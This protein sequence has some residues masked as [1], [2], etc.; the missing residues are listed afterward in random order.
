MPGLE[1]IGAD[2]EVDELGATVVEVVGAV[3]VV[4]VVVVV[5]AMIDPGESIGTMNL[6][7]GI[8]LGTTAGNCSAGWLASALDI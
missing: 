2:E 1:V 4:D 8:Q 5:G 6:E 3:V 7:G